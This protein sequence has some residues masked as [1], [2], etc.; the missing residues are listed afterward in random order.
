M[1]QALP[2][3]AVQEYRGAVPALIPPTTRLH[4]QWLQAHHEWGPGAHEDGFGLHPSDDVESA[5]GFA[6][7]VAALHQQSDAVLARRAT[8]RWIVEDDRVLGGIALRHGSNE[9][10]DRL[11]HIGYGVCPSARGRGI[12]SWALGEMLV[13]AARCGM[14]RGAPGLRV[15]QPR[16][17]PH[18][19]AQRRHRRT[20][21][22]R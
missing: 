21:P 20:A 8:C 5:D 16:L 17:D 13:L 9:V 19:G 22:G 4:R 18:G 10:T 7:W 11:G 2:A 1:T 3:D 6:A 15:G 12:G 14:D